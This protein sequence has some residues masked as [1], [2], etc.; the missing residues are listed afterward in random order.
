MTTTKVIPTVG[1]KLPI[2]GLLYAYR[3][4]ALAY[5]QREE[6]NEVNHVNGQTYTIDEINKAII[7]YN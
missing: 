2:W 5:M 7:R 4:T 3:S 6:L 1:Y